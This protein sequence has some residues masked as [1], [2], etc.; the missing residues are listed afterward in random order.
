MLNKFSEFFLLT[1]TEVSVLKNGV[2][3]FNTW[4]TKLIHHGGNIVHNKLHFLWENLTKKKLE[5]K[6]ISLVIIFLD[7]LSVSDCMC[8]VVIGNEIIRR[9]SQK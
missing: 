1:Y 6:Y 4:C 9:L 5:K 7:D 8:E 2:N 3:W